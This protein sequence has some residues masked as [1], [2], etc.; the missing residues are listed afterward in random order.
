MRGSARGHGPAEIARDDDV[1]IGTA[2]T[3]LRS[4]PERVHAARP[5]GAITTTDTHGAIAALRLLFCQA[6]PDRFDAF[7]AGPHEHFAGVIT[8]TQLAQFVRSI[9]FKS[10]R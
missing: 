10:P 1:G 8:D 9:H 5:H 2:D 3:L 7:L 6:V 4:V